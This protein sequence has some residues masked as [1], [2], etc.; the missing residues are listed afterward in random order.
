MISGI[1]SNQRTAYSVG[2]GRDRSLQ[3]AK[4]Y[5]LSA[6][7]GFTL[8][9][10]MVACAVLSIGIVFIYESFF[11]LLEA[12]D[13]YENYVRIAPIANEKMWQAQD[14]LER[15]GPQ[16]QI[17]TQGEFLNRNKH[18]SWKLAY[19]LV[20]QEERGNLYQIDLSISF[21]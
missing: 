15:L 18:F 8:I 20:E 11:R 12:F 6:K 13:Y 21:K 3:N 14:A 2:N 9:E 16:A 10:V 17:D 7:R 4:R 5:P 1:G 19:G